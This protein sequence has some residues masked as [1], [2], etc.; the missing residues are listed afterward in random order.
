VVPSP[1]H[2]QTGQEAWEQEDYRREKMQKE[3]VAAFPVK[4]N[5]VEGQDYLGMDG[6]LTMSESDY[7]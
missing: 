4:R 5:K 2:S 7:G 1:H 6:F 3:V